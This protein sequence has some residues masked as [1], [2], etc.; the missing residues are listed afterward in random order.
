MQRQVSVVVA[1]VNIKP[2]ASG[3]DLIPFCVC[4]CMWAFVCVCVRVCVCVCV[5][6]FV[7]ACAHGV[8]V[9]V[10]AC[11]GVCKY[12]CE[13]CVCSRSNNIINNNNNT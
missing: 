6:V 9:R 10:H 3:Q 13:G 11:D 2:G 8:R 4:V 7:R 1:K 5:C 12:A